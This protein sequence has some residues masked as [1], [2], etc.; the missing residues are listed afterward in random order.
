MA[1][2]NQHI[3]VHF[4]FALHMSDP[5]YLYSMDVIKAICDEHDSEAY[6][7][8][9]DDALE[10]MDGLRWVILQEEVAYRIARTNQ[11]NV[12]PV[13]GASAEVNCR[14]IACPAATFF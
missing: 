2:V 11:E 8:E 1:L 3:C 14:I 7:R 4:A 12:G 10:A 9:I 6:T 13:A 5:S